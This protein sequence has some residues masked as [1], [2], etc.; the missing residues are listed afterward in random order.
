MRYRFSFQVPGKILCVEGRAARLGK[1]VGRSGGS[2]VLLVTDRGVTGAHLTD[3]VIEGIAGGGAEVVGIFDG[4]PA[5]PT[6]ETVDSC[7]EEALLHRADCLVSVGGGSVIDTAKGT[8]I[9]VA[10]DGDIRPLQWDEYVPSKPV[11]PHIAVPTTAGTGS[12]S[13]YIAMLVDPESGRKLLFHG[14]DLAPKVAV[15]DPLMTLSLPPALTASTGIDALTHAVETLHSV[16][17][18]PITDALALA[19]IEL[20]SANLE[21]AFRDGSDVDARSGMLVAA[22]MAGIGASNAFVG[23]VH[24]AAHAVGAR[25]GVQHGVATAVM[26]PYGMEYNLRFEGVPEAYRRA[27]VAMG[28]D[29]TGLDD[30]EAATKTIERVRRL[31]SS[32]N[33]PSRLSELGVAADDLDGLTED[34]LADK[35]IMVNPGEQTAEDVNALLRKAL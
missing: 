32:L 12:E 21:R 19:A 26:L 33:V 7:R 30:K 15:L 1:L 6:L 14:A 20:I 2:R 25:F 27:A 29:V 8:L 17:S 22:N 9:R 16:F 35:S 24:A 11:W 31:A 5:D 23:I 3:A 10:E 18:E 28:V 4:V 34:T 13:T